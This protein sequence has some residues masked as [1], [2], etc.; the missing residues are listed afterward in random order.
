MFF[1][2]IVTLL[3]MIAIG[4]IGTSSLGEGIFGFKTTASGQKV[5]EEVRDFDLAMDTFK[6]SDAQ[7]RSA[8]QV[9]DERNLGVDGDWTD[10]QVVAE[11]IDNTGLLEGGSENTVAGPVALTEIAS[12]TVDGLYITLNGEAG[13]GGLSD[14][15]CNELNDLLGNDDQ[16]LYGT[17]MAPIIPAVAADLSDLFTAAPGLELGEGTEGACVAID[18]VN[19]LVFFA[20]QN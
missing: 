6:V 17:E 19:T 15:L 1:K 9:A 7:V 5:L 2:P 16:V 8:V 18:S 14:D 4:L 3:L 13:A 20:Q 11:L 12:G 10:A